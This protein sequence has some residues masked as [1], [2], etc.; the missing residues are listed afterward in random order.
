MANKNLM[1]YKYSKQRACIILN[2]NYIPNKEEHIYDEINDYNNYYFQIE[3]QSSSSSIS[4]TSSIKST[5]SYNSTSSS[6]SLNLSASNI[7]ILNNSN[8]NE[9]ELLQNNRK[10]MKRVRFSKTENNNDEKSSSSSLVTFLTKIRQNRVIIQNSPSIELKEL[11]LETNQNRYN[12]ILKKSNL[13]KN[14]VKEE[15]LVNILNSSNRDENQNLFYSF[16]PISTSTASLKSEPSSSY[17][18]SS[19][20]SSNSSNTSQLL[21]SNNNREFNNIVEE[22]ITRLMSKTKGNHNCVICY[23]HKNKSLDDRFQHK[24]EDIC[25]NCSKNTKNNRQTFTLPTPNLKR[26]IEDRLSFRV[27]NLTIDDL[28][29][30]YHSKN[31]L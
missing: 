26:N 30:K 11:K 1:N 18:C 13:N 29:R 14:N 15:E 2:N 21:Q 25:K 5:D 6:S 31:T 10:S 12:S 28:K 16:V 22:F 8:N 19:S 23:K 3:Q 27:T 7:M 20:S 4:P 24:D 9:E 17:E